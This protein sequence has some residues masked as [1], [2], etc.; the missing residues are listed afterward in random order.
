MTRHQDMAQPPPGASGWGDDPH[1][2][3]ADLQFGSVHQRF[4]WLEAGEFWMGSPEGEAER[5]DDEG[6]MHRVKLTRGF[7]LAD[8][9]CS[10]A[11]WMAVMG[12][13]PSHFRGDDRRPVEQVSW[14]DV[15]EFFWALQ[16][17]LPE[18][19]QADLPTEAEWEYACRAGTPTPFSFGGQISPEK[20]NYHGGRPYAG[21]A[22]GEAR[23]ATVAVGSLPANGWGL[24]EMHGNVWEWCADGMR[25]YTA[26]AQEDPVGPAGGRRVLRGGAWFYLGR[27]CRSA[28]RLAFEPGF[29]DHSLGF[30]LALRS[31]D[32][33]GQGWAGGARQGP[34]GA[35]P[36]RDFSPD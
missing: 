24:Y 17:R 18:G 3:Y 27:S 36:A 9:A 26:Q 21:G 11:L 16:K 15:Q 35:G 31:K 2:V 7:W 34:G 1:G 4:R 6:P 14:D 29:A 22:E 10:Q 32:E 25:E 33:T 12:K 28:Q 19:L 23:R 30:R 5:F 20:V 8:T 13:N